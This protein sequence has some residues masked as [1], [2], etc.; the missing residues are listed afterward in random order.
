MAHSKLGK[1]SYQN[2]LNVPLKKA[3]PKTKKDVSYIIIRDEAL[4]LKSY[5]VF[6]ISPFSVN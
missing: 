5:L 6:T 2:K 1:A 4:L 3:F